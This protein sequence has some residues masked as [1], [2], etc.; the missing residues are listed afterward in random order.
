MTD[1]QIEQAKTYIC[2]SFDVVRLL[3]WRVDELV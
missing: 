3:A 1:E 2:A